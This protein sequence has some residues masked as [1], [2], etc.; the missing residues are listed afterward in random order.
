MNAQSLGLAARYRAKIAAGEIEPDAAQ[1]R[2]AQRLA[3]LQGEL[4][5]R[6]FATK[7]SA[8][9][10]L[11]ARHEAA[12]PTKGVYIHGA[13]GRGKTMLMDMFHEAA[14]DLP[15]RRIHFH[16]FMAETHE[17]I[18]AWR[19]RAKRGEVKGV[20][21]IA[22]VARDIAETARLICF[23]EFHVRDIADAMI[24]GRLFT[25]LLARRVVIVATSN[26]APEALY[27]GG[28]NRAL[29]LPFIDL[30]RTRLDILHLDARTDYRLEKLNGHQVYFHPLGPEARQQMDAMWHHVAGR[31]GGAAAEIAVGGRGIKV[32]AAAMGAARFSFADLCERPLG[33]RDYLKLARTYHTLFLDGVPTLGPGRRNE[34]RRFID[35]VDTLYDNRVKLIVSAAAEPAA[36]YP[37]GEGADDFM[38]TASR[39]IEMRSH[40]YLAAAH[41]DGDRP[42]RDGRSPGV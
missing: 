29:F 31:G 39:L 16:E 20:D 7:S 42:P 22:P 15:K 37:V 23:D 10:W 40:G 6:R 35:L 14:P 5:N 38:R 30:L 18:H 27:A 26:T 1:K 11:F 25:A 41:G 3:L 28:L 34:A 33:A 21:P 12:N 19:E 17:R 36:L 2:V 4:E 24:L 8:L 13:V 32:P 9:G